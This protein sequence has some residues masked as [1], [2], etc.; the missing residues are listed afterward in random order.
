MIRQRKPIARKTPVKRKRSKPRRSERVRDP[1][2]L[3]WLHTMPCYLAYHGGCEGPIE[4]DHV[5][6]RPL[7][8]RCDDRGAIALCR[9]HHASRHG[10]WGYFDRWDSSR[11]RAWARDAVALHLEAH[12]LGHRETAPF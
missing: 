7:G 5:A 6:P 4:A 3:A 12:S 9:R 11:M 10:R 1:E 8:R 2:Y